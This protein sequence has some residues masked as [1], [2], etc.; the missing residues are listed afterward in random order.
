MLKNKLFFSQKSAFPDRSEEAMPLF[1]FLRERLTLKK[2][3]FFRF[4]VFMLLPVAISVRPALSDEPP[5]MLSLEQAIE[6]ALDRNRSIQT[7]KNNLES[8]ALNL[9]TAHSDF[10]V[11]FRPVAGAG[12][13][14]GDSDIST[15]ISL[16][17]NMS[18]GMRV[19]VSPLI[20]RRDGDYGSSLGLRLDVPLFRYFGEL[21]NTQYIRSSEFSLRSSER[22]LTS[23][24]ETIVLDTVTSFYA[25]LEQ[26][27]NV[28]MNR[29]LAERFKSHAAIAQIKTDIGLAQPLDVYRSRIREKDAEVDLTE[30]L[31]N[32]QNACDQLK[33]MLAIPQRTAID[34]CDTP[35][36]IP[37][38]DMEAHQIETIAFEHSITIK[39]ALDQLN[40]SQRDARIAEHYLLPDLTL[41][42]DYI[43]SGLDDHLNRNMLLTTDDI[44]RV[45]L[46]SS[47]DFARTAEKNSYR[48]SLI[49]LKSKELELADTKDQLSKEVRS[50]LDMLEK[51]RER[52]RL[53]EAQI[54]DAMGKLELAEV[55]FN[56]GMADNFDVIEAETEHHLARLHLLSAQ[57]DYIIGTYRLRKI[58]GTLIG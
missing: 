37:A 57:I 21:V 48:Q 53:M 14:D 41:S 17:K 42:M 25:I 4:F 39:S 36:D 38:P 10:D 11:K 6:M 43:R 5:I 40:E 29:F 54:H 15:G 27:K 58:I 19:S 52:I 26:K 30:S 2:K 34:I 51:T 44:W 31:E 47:T 20:S 32:L 35:V 16:S 23:T 49:A 24:K 55:K 50:Q 3:T 13:T 33:S 28:E 22:S 56:N 12:V 7:A 46:T 45:Y 9:N 18:Q 8:A 1:C